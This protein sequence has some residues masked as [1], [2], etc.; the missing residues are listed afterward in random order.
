MTQRQILEVAKREV[1][2]RGRTR[3][4]RAITAI[5][6]LIAIAAPIVLAV[7]PDPSDEL[8]TITIGVGDGAPENFEATLKAFAEGQLIVETINLSLTPTEAVDQMLSDGDIDVAFEPPNILAW[9]FGEDLTIASLIT[10]AL[11]QDAMS[12]R[13][14]DLGLDS[15]DLTTLFTPID[16]TN[17]TIGDD[18]TSEGL[19]SAAAFVGLFT[20]FVLPQIFGQLTLLSVV[21]E[22]S[23]RIVEVLLS[24]LRP[25]TLLLGKIIGLC[26][27]ALVQLTLIVAAIVGSLLVVDQVEIPSSVWQFVPMFAISVFGGLAMYTT[28]F[29]LLGSLISRQE[30]AAQV[31]MPVFVPLMVGY[32]A[33]QSGVWGTADS[34]MLRILTWFP[35]TSPM[36]L[37]VRVARDA[38][39]PFELAIS[40]GLLALGVFLLI[41]LAGRVYEFTLLRTGARVGWR[42]LIKLSTGRAE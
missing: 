24:H 20:A 25:Q 27:L 40:L 22:K 21:E 1:V 11:Q 7:L 14:A 33:G 15:G 3:G 38:I 32:L 35:L 5:M 31:M 9:E 17:R 41:K 30:D 42:E 28:V 19:R 2:T 34:L 10:A 8:Q 39:G 26:A 16:L 13:A 12:S 37:P 6:I 4:F 23:T 29:A 18:D 36:I